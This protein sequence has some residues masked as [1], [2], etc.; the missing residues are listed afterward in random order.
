MSTANSLNSEP[1]A[2]RSQPATSST[3]AQLTLPDR[4]YEWPAL[5]TDHNPTLLVE[6]TT[7]D[8]E[9]TTLGDHLPVWAS[10][11]DPLTTSLDTVS[12]QKT[13]E[14]PGE[15][16]P[17]EFYTREAST[18]IA[19]L[20]E[21]GYTVDHIATIGGWDLE[22]VARELRRAGTIQPHDDPRTLAHLYHDEDLD[23]SISQIARDAFGDAV[24]PETVRTRM[25]WFGIEREDRHAGTHYESLLQAAK[26]GSA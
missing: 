19:D 7:I 8:T 6:P 20:Y 2:I 9:A 11:P 18:A 10:L 3:D 4:T 21:R 14:L 15:Q 13:E 24:C 12:A 17:L 5:D 23:Y 25:E 22:H 1:M 26:E 16:L